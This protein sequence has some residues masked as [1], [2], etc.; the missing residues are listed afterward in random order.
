[1]YYSGIIPEDVANG[2]GCRVSIFISGCDNQCEECFN[3]ELW[4][5]EHGKKFSNF[6]FND[7]VKYIR[8]P[9][10]KGIT[11]LGGDPLS[12]KN[13]PDILKFILR[14]KKYVKKH[15]DD[16]CDGKDNIWIYSG[17]TYDE[18]IKRN[19][20]NQT[21]EILDN[22][23]VLVDGRYIKG[24]KSFALKF[25]GSSNQRVIDLNKTRENNNKIVLLDL[26]EDIHALLEQEEEFKISLK[27]PKES[28]KNQREKKKSLRHYA[29]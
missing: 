29:I 4:D 9:L 21:Q 15:K 25:R 20:N 19:D 10:I 16:G 3:P 17:Y 27:I 18:L 14:Y 2:L 8:N 24:L 1:M 13:V 6:T 22:C 28:K 11:I 23:D 7:I 12:P 5:Y 26:G